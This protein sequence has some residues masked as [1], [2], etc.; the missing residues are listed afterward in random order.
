LEWIEV[1][2]PVEICFLAVISTRFP[3]IALRPSYSMGAVLNSIQRVAPSLGKILDS[4]T[5]AG[6]RCSHSSLLIHSI[7][8]GLDKLPESR[9]H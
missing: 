6:T 3:M 1:E 2:E 8:S 7:S 4:Y 5:G 9:A